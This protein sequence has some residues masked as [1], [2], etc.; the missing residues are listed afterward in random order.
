MN[1]IV[2][3]NYLEQ[4]CITLSYG[5]KRIGISDHSILE[6]IPELADG[7]IPLESFAFHPTGVYF[8]G[9]VNDASAIV[10]FDTGKSRTM[11]NSDLLPRELIASDKSRSY[12]MGEVSLAFGQIRFSIYYPRVNQLRRNI[13]TDL[14]MGIEVGSDM[15]KYFDITVARSGRSNYL[16]IQTPCYLHNTSISPH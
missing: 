16:Y 11:V 10:Y 4:T 2:G 12:F 1:G 14:P 6:A 9:L 5:E 3:L 7:A 8:G 15:L 13:D